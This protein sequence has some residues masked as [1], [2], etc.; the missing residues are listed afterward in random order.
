ML[1]IQEQYNL[2]PGNYAKEMANLSVLPHIKS[3]A[4]DTAKGLN[5]T[6]SRLAARA[7]HRRPTK[8]C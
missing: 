8:A 5:K 3:M 1:S 6:I 2:V 7:M 4:V